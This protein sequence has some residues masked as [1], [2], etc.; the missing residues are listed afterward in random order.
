MKIITTFVCLVLIACILTHSDISLYYALSGLELWYNNMVPALLPFMILSGIMIRLKLT[1]GFT[2]FVY[3]VIKPLFR[4]TPH[5]CYAM[6]MGFLCGFPMG[7]KT[8]RDLYDRHLISLREAEFLLAFCNNIGPVYFCSFVIPLLHRQLI[9]PYLFGMYGLP[10]LYGLFLRYTRFKDLKMSME[11]EGSFGSAG[12]SDSM[13]PVTADNTHKSSALLVA[14]DESVLSSVQSIINLGGYMILFNLLNIVPHIL[15]NDIPVMT[16]P[17]FEI[18]GGLKLLQDSM[19]L[20][21]LLLLPFGGLSCIVQTYSCI[22]NTPL[23]IADYTFHK[24]I[25]VGITAVYY[26]LWFVLSS[27]SFMR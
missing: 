24:L 13:H 7:A 16:A 4:V 25:L 18:T 14:I 3:P 15:L 23:S 27:D 26:F 2:V 10:F 12:F 1:E 11:A 6:I 17:L 8:I 19:P 5:V 20:Y 9:A 22:K 21:T